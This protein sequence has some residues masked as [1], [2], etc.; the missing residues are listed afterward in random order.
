MVPDD[1]ETLWIT[2]QVRQQGTWPGWLIN[3]AEV[4]SSTA[5]SNAANNTVQL[6]L[7]VTLPTIPTN[8][9]PPITPPTATPTRDAPERVF[10]PIVMKQFVPAAPPVHLFSDNFNDGVLTGWT[11]NGGNWYN[12][13]N[14]MR[15]QRVDFGI[16]WN[17]K[18]VSGANFTYEGDVN[19][20]NSARA[21]LVFRSSPDGMASYEAV[22]DA[23]YSEFK[24]IKRPGG[25]V[26]AAYPWAVSLNH[27]YHVKVV[28]NGSTMEGYLDG[29]KR[30]T[31]TDTNFT[32]GQ[33]GVV[34]SAAIN[35]PPIGGFDNLEAWALP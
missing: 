10:L 15:G 13:G 4:R 29:V 20:I 27:W 26:L 21:G 8:T 32:N 25:A 24:I 11:P 34:T 14:Y 31:A 17:I 1:S 12:A 22:L 2:V 33:F 18:N 7:Q 6:W 9:P 35:A 16:A 3:R 23:Q 30:L 19:L 28:V 5:D